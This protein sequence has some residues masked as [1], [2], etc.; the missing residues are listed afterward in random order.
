[1]CKECVTPISWR[2]SW[3]EWQFTQCLNLYRSDSVH[4]DWGSGG[5]PTNPF[6]CKKL[7]VA[8]VNES[9]NRDDNF[10]YKKVTNLTSI[11]FASSSVDSVSAYDLL[12]H[13]PRTWP[14]GDDGVRYPFIELMNEIYRILKPGGIF[15]S[16][17]PAF[18]SPQ[19]F[20]DPTHVNFISEETISYF[21]ENSWAAHLGYG[22]TANFEKIHQSWLRGSGPLIGRF[23][24]HSNS[25]EKSINSSLKLK[26]KHLNR[27][28]RMSRRKDA[29]SLLWVL[30]KPCQEN[31]IEGMRA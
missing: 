11:D 24:D 3:F 9:H 20:Q 10:V 5:R 1:M 12:E 8:D 16:V 30:R 14:N 26:L 22:L 6:S 17:T 7:Y 18:P 19:A 4:L 27:F 15:L 25:N 13:I 2:P 31:R 28:F 23:P 29:Y 21:D